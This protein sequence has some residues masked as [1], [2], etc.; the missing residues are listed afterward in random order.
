MKMLF[1]TSV[2]IFAAPVYIFVE[3]KRWHLRFSI[4]WLGLGI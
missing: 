3:E 4:R 1:E 2:E